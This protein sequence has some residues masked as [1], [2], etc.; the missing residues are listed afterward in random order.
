MI[1]LNQV[2]KFN[3]HAYSNYMQTL[4]PYFSTPKSL[5][6]ITMIRYYPKRILII[7]NLKGE[8]EGSLRGFGTKTSIQMKRLTSNIG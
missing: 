2:Y 8:G 6:C 1:I 7:K 5:I 3:L 4:S